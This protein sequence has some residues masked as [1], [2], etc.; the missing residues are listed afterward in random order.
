MEHESASE[1]NAGLGT[2]VAKPF[3]WTH[4]IWPLNQQWDDSRYGF[5]IIYDESEEVDSRYQ[6]SW[7]ED[8]AES[9]ATLEEAQK[10]CQDQIDYW[11]REHVLVVPNA[12]IT[13]G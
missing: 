5:S 10:W 6:A 11:V 8:D 9:F 4:G 12:K 3:E 1:L 7:G 2:A 13:G